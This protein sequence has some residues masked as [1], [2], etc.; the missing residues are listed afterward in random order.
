MA[1]GIKLM[2]WGD[3]ASF[4]RPEMK[5]ERVSYD[6]MTP[7]AARGILEAIHWKPGI[8]WVVDKIHVLSPIRFT[9]VRRNEV[10]CK[11]PT[12]GNVAAA[13]RGEPV[14][15]GIAV[16][17]FRQQRAAM[18]LRDVRYGIVAHI[19]IIRPDIG[20][21]GKPLANPEAKHLES[22]KRRASKGQFF[23]QP[24]LGT[25]EF[26]ASFELVDEFP[27]CAGVLRGERDLGMMLRDLE[28]TPDKDGK[29]IESN[30]GIRL[31]ANARF[32]NAVMRDGVIHVPE[33]HRSL[34]DGEDRQ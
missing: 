21:D 23:H 14:L 30:E 32:F 25:R 15:L 33:N 1:Y 24:Y 2:V 10:S 5:V 22:F 8:K 29:I 12:K 13:M 34:D 3:Y 31:S 18:I 17:E 6:V 20:P 27:E 26:P 11:I 28:F 7:S 4:N 9:H 19:E 16:E